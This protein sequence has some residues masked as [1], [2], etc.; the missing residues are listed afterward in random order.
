MVYKA[1]SNL[2]GNPHKIFMTEDLTQK[3]YEIALKLLQLRSDKRIDP[4]W[5]QDGKILY[6]INDT[7]KPVRMRSKNDLDVTFPAPASE[8]TVPKA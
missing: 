6:K 3:N 1:K 5:T 2:K 7:S 8:N 4:F